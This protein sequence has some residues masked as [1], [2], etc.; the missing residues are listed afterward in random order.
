VEQVSILLVQFDF[1]PS[2]W[3][4]AKPRVPGGCGDSNVAEMIQMTIDRGVR[5]ALS[6]GICGVLML[7][8]FHPLL[9]AIVAV[10]LAP[11]H[12]AARS[13]RG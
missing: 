13:W 11:P 8:D 3:E 10:T 4:P 5:T 9:A 7:G 2:L 12:I 6:R 1:I